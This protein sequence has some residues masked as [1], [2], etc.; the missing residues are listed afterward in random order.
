[1]KIYDVDPDDDEVTHG[2]HAFAFIGVDTRRQ[3]VVAAFKGSNQTADFIDDL[4]GAFPLPAFLPSSQPPCPPPASQRACLPAAC[5][6][7]LVN[8]A[9]LFP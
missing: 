6:L 9:D 1:M 3:W 4:D 2:D 7:S 8:Q 5:L